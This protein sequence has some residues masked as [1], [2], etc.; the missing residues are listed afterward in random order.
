MILTKTDNRLTEKGYQLMS[1]QDFLIRSYIVLL[2]FSLMVEVD[3]FSIRVIGVESVPLSL[4]IIMT[5][6]VFPICFFKDFLSFIKKEI[7]IISAAVLFIASGVISAAGSPFPLFYGLKW[8]FNYT[9]FLG[10][11]FLLVFLF[12]KDSHLGLFFCKAAAGLALALALVSLVEA[13]HDG[14]YIFLADTFRLGERQHFAQQTRI[15][16]TLP[17]PNLFGCY[18]SLGILMLLYVR[19]EARVHMGLF[20]PAI[21]FLSIAVSLSSSRN[22]MISLL[23]PVG[24]LFF[25]RHM[26]K[27][28]LVVVI[29]TIFS[30]GV[31]SPAATRFVEFLDTELLTKE[32]WVDLTEDNLSKKQKKQGKNK[33][34]AKKAKKKSD[35]TVKPPLKYSTVDVRI[36]LW[37][38]ALAMFSDYPLFGIGPGGYNV[39]L[40]DYAS[41]SLLKMEHHKIQ[42]NYLNAHNGALNVIAEFGVAGALVWLFMIGYLFTRM[43]RTHGIFPPAA[44]HVV[45]LGIICSFMPDAFYYNRFYMVLSITLLFFFTLQARRFCLSPP[46][47][48]PPGQQATE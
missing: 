8:L 30:I 14:V 21:L 27:T 20:L 17:N 4:F 13:S 2:L 24:C 46:A 12:S 28:A 44:S 15:A 43:V 45:L 41:E 31:L 9:L 34:K 38:S 19:Q 37:Q 42:N 29:I 22:S 3:L 10:V 35:K 5:G 23:L 6:V 40:K 47:E 25:N 33:L 26:I 36:K 18:M 7:V 32:A 48:K 11:S 1:K 39:A 16:A